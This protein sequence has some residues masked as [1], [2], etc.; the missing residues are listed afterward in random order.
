VK[1]TVVVCGEMLR[2][3]VRVLAKQREVNDAKAT[4]LRVAY[5]LVFLGALGIG[6]AASMIAVSDLVL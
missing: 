2:G 3:E 6:A 5:W 4:R 1:P